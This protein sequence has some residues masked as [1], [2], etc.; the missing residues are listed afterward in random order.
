MSV[1]K[2]NKRE[3]GKGP[4]EAQKK[5]E[6]LDTRYPSMRLRVVPL[7]LFKSV[8]D[9]RVNMKA[10]L[11]NIG[12]GSLHGVD[13]KRL[14]EEIIIGRDLFAIDWFAQ[15][16]EMKIDNI[17][18]INIAEKIVY[19]TTVDFMFKMNFFMLITNTLAKNESIDGLLSFDVLKH[20]RE[21]TPEDLEDTLNQFKG[22]FH[23]DDKFVN[24][25]R[26]YDETFKDI[27]FQED[28]DDDYDGDIGVDNRWDVEGS[29]DKVDAS[30]GEDGSGGEDGSEDDYEDDDS[31]YG[32]DK[33]GKVTNIEESHG[34]DGVDN[35]DNTS[36]EKVDG[37]VVVYEID[38]YTE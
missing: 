8:C 21:D 15:F 14:Q 27:K 5:H 25:Y 32:D 18:G 12:F 28:D 2:V 9:G 38:S 19:A 11:E 13:I 33:D 16:G 35:K 29:C 4:I 7:A 31:P 26:R 1:K 22:M 34:L 23:E 3:K 17:R 20:V 37:K 36:K 10:F 30:E 6:L 24:F